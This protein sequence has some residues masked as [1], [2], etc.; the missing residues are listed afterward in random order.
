VGNVAGRCPLATEAGPRQH[1]EKSLEIKVYPN[2][3]IYILKPEI[4]GKQ[5]SKNFR[6]TQKN[7]NLLKIKR[8]Y[9]ILK[10]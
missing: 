9:L 6:K 4:S 8:V 7:N 10:Y 2:V 1:S 5:Q 3:D